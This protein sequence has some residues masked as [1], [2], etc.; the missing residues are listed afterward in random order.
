M[1]DPLNNE[2]GFSLPEVMLSMM[3]LVM[4]ITVLAGFWRALSNE[5]QAWRQYR[6]L[7]RHAWLQTQPVASPPPAGWQRNRAQTTQ[8]GCVSI[9]VKITSPTG[10]QGRMTRLHCPVSQ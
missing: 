6:Q 4:V 1:P 5:A 9:S 10:R 3:L 7:W 2:K 8:A